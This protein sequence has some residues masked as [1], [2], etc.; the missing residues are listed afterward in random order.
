MTLEDLISNTTLQGD[1]RISTFVSV[2]CQD[3]ENVLKVIH[4]TEQL[5][6][7]DI[8]ESWYNCE[9]YYMFCGND[10]YLHIEIETPEVE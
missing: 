3:I 9:V 4:G 8:E 1:I 7:C 2:H 5:R 10:G 6:L